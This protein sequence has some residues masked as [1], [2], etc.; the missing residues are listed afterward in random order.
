VEGE[1]GW[2]G[3]WAVGGC[4]PR[5]TE[6][7]DC[8]NG[9]RYLSGG[10]GARLGV[11]HGEIGGQEEGNAN[12]D[13]EVSCAVGLELR[14]LSSLR[15]RCAGSGCAVRPCRACSLLSRSSRRCRFGLIIGVGPVVAR[16]ESGAH[17]FEKI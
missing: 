8:G 13:G 1:P 7:L 11:G 9:G 2:A 10:G 16:E 6:G 15:R 12:R 17:I 4:L 14:L 5:G 3:E